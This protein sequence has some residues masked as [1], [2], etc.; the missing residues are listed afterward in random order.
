MRECGKKNSQAIGDLGRFVEVRFEIPR[1]LKVLIDSGKPFHEAATVS[2]NERE[3]G[4]A[5]RQFGSWSPRKTLLPVFDQLGD[6]YDGCRVSLCLWFCR[7][8]CQLWTS[9]EHGPAANGVRLTPTRYGLVCECRRRHRV[10]CELCTRVVHRTAH[11]MCV[12][13]SEMRRSDV[14]RIATTWKHNTTSINHYNMNVTYVSCSQLN[15]LFTKSTQN[16]M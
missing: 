2:R 12:G 15:D 8:E 11:F 3:T 6:R 9:N 13:E 16:E 5:R 1:V 7:Q 14:P 10:A 4:S